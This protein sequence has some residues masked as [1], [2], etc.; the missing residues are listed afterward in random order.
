M[1]FDLQNIVKYCIIFNKIAPKL[2]PKFNKILVN[3][4][5]FVTYSI[6]GGMC[7]TALYPPF[8]VAG[9]VMTIGGLYGG[10]KCITGAI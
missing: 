2:H 1:L 3:F 10:Y 4:S 8:A 7:L 6:I 5:K 9:Y